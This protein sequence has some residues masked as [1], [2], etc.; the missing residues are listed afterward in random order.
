MTAAGVVLVLVGAFVAVASVLAVAPSDGMDLLGVDLTG[1]TAATLFL[2]LAAVY[3]LTG[4]LIVLRRPVG[5]P[6]G[7]VVGVVALLIGLA[8]MPSA[9]VNGIPTVGVAVFVL[10]ALA[11]GGNDFRRG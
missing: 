2:V 8:Q 3:A 11:I 1:G 6:I 7:F 10:Y 5:R 4:L 9:G